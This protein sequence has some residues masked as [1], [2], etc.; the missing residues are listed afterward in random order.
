MSQTF[1]G[2]LAEARATLREAVQSTELAGVSDYDRAGIL[3]TSAASRA[4]TGD[5]ENARKSADGGLALARRIGNPSQL[6]A[7][8][9]TASLTRARDNR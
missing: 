6:A 2:R 9:W 1:T 7:S 3:Q 4:L 8:L 5:I